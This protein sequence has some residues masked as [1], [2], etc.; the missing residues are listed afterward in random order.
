MKPGT[1]GVKQLFEEVTQ[2]IRPWPE[3]NQTRF[4]RRVH[5]LQRSGM[6]AYEAVRQAYNENH[7]VTAQG[8][9]SLSYP[10]LPS[11]AAH[12]SPLRGGCVRRIFVPRRH[13]VAGRGLLMRRGSK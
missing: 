1:N 10:W 4:W 9:G 3:P 13:G 6:G 5:D 12:I 8:G 2:M 7:P 11:E